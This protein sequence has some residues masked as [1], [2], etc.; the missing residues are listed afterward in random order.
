M[1]LH[2]TES[3]SRLMTQNE[4]QQLEF[5]EIKKCTYDIKLMNSKRRYRPLK[6]FA[7]KPV[8]KLTKEC[9]FLLL[10]SMQARIQE[11]GINNPE[12]KL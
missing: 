9:C 11:R 6:I 1:V 2:E 4:Q 10:P 7:T 3:V 5:L 12:L 8:L